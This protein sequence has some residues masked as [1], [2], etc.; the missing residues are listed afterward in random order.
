MENKYKIIRFGED[1]EGYNTTVLNEREVR[2]AAGILFL[3]MFISVLNVLFKGD[4]VLLKYAI[5]FF[6][7]DMLIRVFINPRFSASLIL[8]RLIVSR[9]VPEYIGAV[10]KRFAWI[11]GVVIGTAMFIL[12]IVVNSYSPITGIMCFICL[13]FLFFESSFGICIG[14]KVYSWFQKEKAMY[15]PGEVCEITKRVAI[16]KTS[17]TQIL[18][19]IGFI[20]F[21]FLTVWLFK[22]DFSKKPEYLFANFTT[23]HSK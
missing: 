1:V 18:I 23:I 21:I 17:R 6:L 2:A 3:L 5:T 7:T 14:C 10:Q 19:L 9:Q 22:D 12:M 15:C 8:G 20:A 4:F 11:I 13:I 16:Q